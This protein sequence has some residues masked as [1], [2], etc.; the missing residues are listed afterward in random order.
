MKAAKYGNFPQKVRIIEVGPR[1]G[2]QNEKMVL[3]AEE[4]I[5][6][7]KRLADSGLETIEVTSFVRPSKIPQ[8][9]DAEA[10]YR[11]V[12]QEIGGLAIRLPCLVPNL[13]GLELAIAA[14]VKEIALFTAIS[15]T[16]NRKNIN[17]TI[18]E[19]FV[20]F[21]PLVKMANENHLS[22]RGYISTVFG[23]P[24]EGKVSYDRLLEVTEKLFEL[25]V[26][27]VALGD[28]IGVGGP[29]QIDIIGEM[30]A[31]RYE[32]EKFSM[33]FHDTE[34]T[35]LAN[36]YRSLQLGFT[37][38]DASAGGLGGCPYARGATGNLSTEDAVNFLE[39]LGIET[40][41]NMEKLVDASRYIYEKLGRSCVSKFHNAYLGRR[42]GRNH[43]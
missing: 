20:R 41:V 16:F 5:E 43:E 33:H 30:F 24:Y 17:A 18:K 4:K 22:I 8:M 31:K 9:G 28:T 37:N 10:L 14:G 6:F 11:R 29:R 23:C 36:I 3:G 35:A 7:I 40:G 42:E 32:L 39:K 19:S 26:Y 12:N 1:D 2:L 21:A 25:G 13:K 15:D 34:G 38:F 27:E